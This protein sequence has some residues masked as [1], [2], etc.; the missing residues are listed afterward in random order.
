MTYRDFCE[1]RFKLENEL[2]KDVK[3]IDI[4]VRYDPLP[5]IPNI[6][7]K[8]ISTGGPLRTTKYHIIGG[9]DHNY[10]AYLNHWITNDRDKDAY[11]SFNGTQEEF[12]NSYSSKARP[13]ILHF[14][15]HN[16]QPD[17][18]HI[19]TVMFIKGFLLKDMEYLITQEIHN[20]RTRIDQ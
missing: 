8:F 14:H 17:S 20:L 15:P 3:V 1:A 9:P 7:L 4:P 2:H 12:D 13:N 18:L 11:I 5:E 16:R 10:T 6:T 19:A